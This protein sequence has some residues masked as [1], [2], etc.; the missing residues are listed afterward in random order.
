VSVELKD[1][2][3]HSYTAKIAKG[4]PRN[5]MTEDEV[6]EKFLRNASSA[7]A[8]MQA[9]NLANVVRSLES[10]DDVKKL[11]SLLTPQ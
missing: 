2:T 9:E 5:P 4:D 11:A 8:P 10:I 7:I 1:G 6:R 3:R